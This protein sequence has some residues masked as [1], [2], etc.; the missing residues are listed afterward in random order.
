M[1]AGHQSP[2][3][4]DGWRLGPAASR[5]EQLWGLAAPGHPPSICTAPETH[6]GAGWG[7]CANGSAVMVAAVLL[8]LVLPPWLLLLLL[9]ALLP[10][11]PLLLVMRTALRCLSW[12]LLTA[13][14]RAAQCTAAV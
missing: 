8:L 3:L 10:R 1:S 5:V 7:G 4:S 11:A 2:A 9:L 13:P 6:V 14:L 12:L